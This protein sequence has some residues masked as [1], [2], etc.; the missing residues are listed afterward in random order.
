MGFSATSLLPSTTLA[1]RWFHRRRSLA[2]AIVMTGLSVGGMLLTPI[3]A[4]LIGTLKL[5]QATLWLSLFYLLGIIPVTLWLIRP[6][7]A[8][9]GLLPDGDNAEQQKTAPIPINRLPSARRHVRVIFSLLP[10]LIYL[11]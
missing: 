1:T 7:P 11:F 5:Q 9:L 6:Y 3:S 4:W 2:V 10:S 8:T